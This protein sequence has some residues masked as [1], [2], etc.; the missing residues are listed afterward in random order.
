MNQ[1]ELSLLYSYILNNELRLKDEINTRQAHLRFREV[2]VTDCIELAFLINQ[3]DTFKETTNHI[4][5]LLN[6]E[7]K[8][9]E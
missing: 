5:I 3:Y 2:S 4:R 6:L 9:D 7:E 8:N 1:K